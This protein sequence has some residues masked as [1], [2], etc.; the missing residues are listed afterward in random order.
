MVSPEAPFNW[1]L[2]LIGTV[3]AKGIWKNIPILQEGRS[4]PVPP[5]PPDIRVV[6]LHAK[7]ML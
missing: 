1:K 4:S 7:A 5:T 3:S 6:L 2:L